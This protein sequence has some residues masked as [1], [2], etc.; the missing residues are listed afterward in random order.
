MLKTHFKNFLSIGLVC[1]LSSC[2]S[3][4]QTSTDQPV[5][6]RNGQAPVASALPKGTLVVVNGTPIT[7]REVQFA[8]ER[9]FDFSTQHQGG[10]PLRKSVIESLIASEVI[11][12]QAKSKLS[13]DVLETIDLQTAAYENELYIKEYLSAT[14][15]PE[16]VS[17]EMVEAYYKSNPEKFGGGDLKTFELLK[18]TK[19]NEAARD[20]FLA[21][22]ESIK[23]AKDWKAISV[24]WAETLGLTYQQA[25][26]NADVLIK[27]LKTIVDD[28]DEGETSNVI[29]IKGN[30]YLV[31]V[32]K[33]R[34]IAPK[35]LV[36]FKT[37]IRE[38]LAPIQLRDAIKK[39]SDQLIK[40]AE[41]RYIDNQ[42]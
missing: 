4:D 20:E 2:G 42:G 37:Q 41:I 35:P 21:S 23:Q 31:R 22:I 13:A 40:N 36:Q 28:L 10:E 9:N 14:I 8:I 38:S 18:T 34:T 16:P 15:T 17:A 3:S 5:S 25:E 24:Q 26:A 33:T 32:I 1:L 27:E 11:R 12:Q 29:L 6:K 39:V 19:A 30:V 7:D